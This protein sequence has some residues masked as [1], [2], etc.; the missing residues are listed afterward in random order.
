MINNLR[1]PMNIKMNVNG[2]VEVNGYSRG[3]LEDHFIAGILQNNKDLTIFEN[4]SKQREILEN[5]KLEL[6]SNQINKLI[7]EVLSCCICMQIYESPVNIK[8]CLHKFCKYCIEKYT[9]TVYQNSIIS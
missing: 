5:F 8:S 6:N 2:D 9:R 4:I 7:K 1:V 3:Q